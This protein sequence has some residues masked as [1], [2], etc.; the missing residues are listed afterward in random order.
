MCTPKGR[1]DWL[2]SSQRLPSL[3]KSLHTNDSRRSGAFLT[4]FDGM[5]KVEITLLA[6]LRQQQV[7]SRF[8][9]IEGEGDG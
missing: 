2:P 1:N 5:R 7:P 3:E 8:Y 4:I 9:K 6:M